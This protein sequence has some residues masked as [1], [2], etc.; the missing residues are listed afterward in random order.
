VNVTLVLFDQANVPSKP[1]MQ[2]RKP[3]V[4]GLLGQSGVLGQRF[5][6]TFRNTKFISSKK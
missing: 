6:K 4:L 2:V 1:G 5:S 3:V